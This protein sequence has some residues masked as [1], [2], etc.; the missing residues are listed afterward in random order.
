MNTNKHIAIFFIM[1]YYIL[2]LQI[3]KNCYTFL[4]LLSPQE[5]KDKESVYSV[6]RV[7]QHHTLYPI[8]YINYLRNYHGCL[9]RLHPD[10]NRTVSDVNKY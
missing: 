4:M 1:P 2:P 6:F 7:T 9:G 3:W 10:D 5:F 8:P